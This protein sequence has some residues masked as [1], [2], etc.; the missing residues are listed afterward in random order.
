[1]YSN[2]CAALNLFPSLSFSN[3]YQGVPCKFSWH[4]REFGFRNPRNF[5]LWNPK[6]GK[7]LLV[8]SE[9][10]GLGI[11]NTAQGIWNPPNDRNSESKF[12]RKRLKSSTWNPESTAWNPET[13]AVL[14]SLTWSEILHKPPKA[15][16][17]QYV[18]SHWQ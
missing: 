1:M 18:T 10:L 13:K 3:D 7:I 9:I 2:I 8:E 4:A 12:H 14:D 17:R 16:A 15:L 6:S 5:C 11:Q